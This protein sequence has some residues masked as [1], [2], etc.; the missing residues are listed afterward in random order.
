[1][2]R[3][4]VDVRSLISQEFAIEDGLAAFAQAAAHSTMKVLL[5]FS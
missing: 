4:A 1:L 2:A 3:R 5:R